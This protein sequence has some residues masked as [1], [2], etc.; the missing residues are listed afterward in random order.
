[1]SC[2]QPVETIEN[3]VLIV[4]VQ[5]LD[6]GYFMWQKGLT[7]ETGADD[8]IYFEYNDQKFGGHDIVTE[9]K[10]DRDGMHAV[11]ANRELVHFYFPPK[12]DNYS[13]LKSGLLKIYSSNSSVLEFHDI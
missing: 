10:I 6:G 1:M 5:E 9:C 2:N 7:I 8:G 12:F 4:A 3:D 13:E 11:L